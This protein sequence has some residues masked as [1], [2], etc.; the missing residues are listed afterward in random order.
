M[1][2]ARRSLSAVRL[3]V[4]PRSHWYWLVLT[5]GLES[6]RSGLQNRCSPSELRQ[7]EKL[8][9]GRDDPGQCFAA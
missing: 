8:T 6:P 7:L 3:P 4:S 9:N 2:K 5:G 1:G